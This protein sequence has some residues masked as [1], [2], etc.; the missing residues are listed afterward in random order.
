MA[1]T[2]MGGTMGLA[3]S[4]EELGGWH[5]HGRHCVISTVMGGT[6]WLALSWEALWGWHCNE[7][8]CV[9]STVMGGTVVLS[10]VLFESLC[11]ILPPQAMH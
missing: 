2:V 9:T 3:L 4:W 7:G 6:E 8:H 10:L 11:H 1:G 5:C